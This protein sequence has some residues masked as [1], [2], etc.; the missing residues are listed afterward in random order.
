MAAGK[1]FNSPVI[2]GGI[3]LSALILWYSFIYS[4][5]SNMASSTRDEL[6]LQESRVDRLEKRIRRAQGAV[7]RLKRAEAEAESLFAKMV[8]GQNAQEVASH[9]QNLVLKEAERAGVTVTLYRSG[10]PRKYQEYLL[11]PVS[12]TLN[13]NS[14]QLMNL[15][16]S[17][18]MYDKIVR[19]RSINISTMR[20]D[21][22]RL[23]VNMEIEALFLG[24]ESGE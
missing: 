1:R 2:R 24:E 3:L 14:T 5:L 19:F 20:G 4:P 10:K 16:S 21:P 23:R 12:F 15:L 8:P 13:C 18:S 7:Q 6:A 22:P 9:L 17:L 11:V